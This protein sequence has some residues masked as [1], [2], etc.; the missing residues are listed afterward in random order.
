AS[1]SNTLNAYSERSRRSSVVLYHCYEIGHAALHPARIA[2]GSCR[3]LLNPLNPLMYTVAGRSALA[4]CEVFERATRRYPRPAFGITSTRID[5]RLVRVQQEVVWQSAFCRLLRFKRQGS[6]ALGLLPLLLVAPMSGHFAT[7]LRGT[8][9]AFLSQQ[10]VYITD[11]QD[12]REV[13]LSE[14]HFDLDDYIDTVASLFRYFEGKV[15]V[16]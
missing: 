4:A 14:G 13:P 5:G 9:E 10:D 12:A 15:H 16:F 1:T 11:W 2:V 6:P 3:W 7:L 8:V